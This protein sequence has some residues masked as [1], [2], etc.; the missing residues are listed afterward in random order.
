[1]IW[2]LCEPV[3]K[4]NEYFSSEDRR[5]D[6]SGV[7]DSFRDKEQLKITTKRDLP[8]TLCRSATDRDGS[9]PFRPLLW[10]IIN[11]AAFQRCSVACWVAGEAP[12]PSLLTSAFIWLAPR[13]APSSQ[14]A[15]EEVTETGG[16]DEDEARRAGGAVLIHRSIRSSPSASQN[17]NSSRT[18]SSKPAANQTLLALLRSSSFF[19][20]FHPWGPFRDPSSCERSQQRAECQRGEGRTGGTSTGTFF[21][22]AST[23]DSL[24]SKLQLPAAASAAFGFTSQS[25]VNKSE[26]SCYKPTLTAFS[27]SFHISSV[28]HWTDCVAGVHGPRWTNLYC[29]TRLTFLLDATSFLMQCVRGDSADVF[30][31]TL[32]IFN[33]S[34]GFAALG[35]KRENGDKSFI[36]MLSKIKNVIIVKRH[37]LST[38]WLSTCDATTARSSVSLL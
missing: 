11:G 13:E 8:P 4:L 5:E 22:T 29:I 35:W 15:A 7:S 37:K 38:S 21:F 28:C 36:C 33:N 1:M 2:I 34:P 26:S 30:L 24:F 10:M 20:Y 16:G 32:I 9:L 31:R 17:Q 18:S 23:S 14:P 19:V 6:V 25:E 3:R 27:S 12:H